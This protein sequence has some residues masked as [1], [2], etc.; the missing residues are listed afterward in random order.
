[1]TKIACFLLSSA[2]SL[3]LAWRIDGPVGL[4]GAI[5]GTLIGGVLAVVGSILLA[6]ARTKGGNAFIGAMLAGV[7]SSFV[8]MG[9]SMLILAVWWR[10]IVPSASLTALAVYLAARFAEAFREPH[11]LTGE[12]RPAGTRGGSR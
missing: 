4:R 2:L 3:F 11:R 5:V 10:E 8:L 12:A 6:R 1:M 7:L 9:L